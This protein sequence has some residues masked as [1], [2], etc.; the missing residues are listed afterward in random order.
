MLN[1]QQT[2]K[3]KLMGYNKYNYINI[4]TLLILFNQFRQN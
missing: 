2:Q 4:L 3:F 1:G